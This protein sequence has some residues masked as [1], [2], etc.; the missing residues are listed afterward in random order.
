MTSVLIV[1]IDPSVVDT[2]DPAISPGITRESIARGLQ[3]TLADMRA[4]G[5][6][7]AM[8]A[9]KP[10]ESAETTIADTLRERAWDVVVIGAGV[11]LPPR[12]LHLFERVVN[13]IHHGAPSAQIAF[14]SSPE[15]SAEA[16]QRW[17][18]R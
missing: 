6:T 2:T 13:A 1:G 17:L 3:E 15:S 5:W 10:D 9:I 11:R 16:A 7:A 12:N 18:V 4:R 8:C 14:N